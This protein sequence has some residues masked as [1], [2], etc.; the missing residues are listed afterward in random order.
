LE[1]S[2]SDGPE[3]GEVGA[4]FE[5]MLGLPEKVSSNNSVAV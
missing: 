1:S 2:Y 4:L 3:T 5:A